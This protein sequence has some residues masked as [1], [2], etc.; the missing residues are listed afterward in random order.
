M[1]DMPIYNEI[2]KC[3]KHGG[4]VTDF[5]ARCSKK[6][7]ELALKH[8]GLQIIKVYDSKGTE[9]IY[10]YVPETGKFNKVV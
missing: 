1:S 5:L 6:T 3:Y 10:N 4:N 8:F 7:I 9:R 2:Y